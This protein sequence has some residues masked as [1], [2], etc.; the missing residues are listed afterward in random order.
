MKNKGMQLGAVL[1]A[2]LLLGMVSIPAVSAQSDEKQVKQ[3]D[4]YTYVVDKKV[5]DK[6]KFLDKIEPI[7][8]REHNVSSSTGQ[9]TSQDFD[10]SKSNTYSQNVLGSSIEGRTYAHGVQQSGWQATYTGDG[11]TKGYWWGSNPYYAD[12]ITLGSQV[13]VHGIS[14][15]V[16]VPP[17]IGFSVSGDTATYSGSWDNEW[18]AIHYY[19]NLVGTSNWALTG[20]DQYDS[21]TFRFGNTDY[22]LYTHVALP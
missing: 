16:S 9:V 21:E 22:T 11:Y 3:I 12:R 6:K 8:D 10:T 14:V 19:N 7:I 20:S 1:A 2:M 4:P 17:S 18:A 5:P 13:V 15:T